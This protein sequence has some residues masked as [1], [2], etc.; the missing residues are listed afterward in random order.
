MESD[1]LEAVNWILDELAGLRLFVTD[2]KKALLHLRDLDRL[3]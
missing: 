3:N 1:I 2:K